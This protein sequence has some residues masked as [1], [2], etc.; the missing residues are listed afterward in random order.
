MGNIKSVDTHTLI[1][2]TFL[3][4][5]SVVNKKLLEETGIWQQFYEY[6]LERQTT[7][8]TPAESNVE[9]L[10]KYLP[11][12]EK[13]KESFTPAAIGV[14]EGGKGPKGAKSSSI[15]IPES[16][17]NAPHDIVS[18]VEYVAKYLE[19]GLDSENVKEA[20]CAAAV[21]MLR[22]Y[23]SSSARKNM[24]WD[25]I[26]ILT[27]P[28][29][30]EMENRNPETFDGETIKNMTLEIFNSMIKLKEKQNDEN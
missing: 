25:K 7:G 22:S 13:I 4:R 28:P 11:R 6:R 9:A 18:S 29:K 15:E 30:S 17:M 26:H 8:M 1:K 21:S 20:P 5:V 10:A 27:F 16:I 14:S 2:D 19:I 12:A 24:F 23:S 3:A